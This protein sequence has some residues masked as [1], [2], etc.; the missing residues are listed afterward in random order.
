MR[1]CAVGPQDCQIAPGFATN[2]WST[3]WPGMIVSKQNYVSILHAET[4]T[5]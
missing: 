5:R 1:R 2:R 3:D 4:G